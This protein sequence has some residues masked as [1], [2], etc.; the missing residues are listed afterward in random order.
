MTSSL[1]PFFEP[2]GVAIIG[3]SASSDKLSYGILKNLISYGYRGGIFPVNPKADEI[4]GLPCYPEIC[5]VPSPVDLAVIVLASKLIPSVLEECGKRGIK[6]AT[7]ISGGFKEVGEEGRSLEAEVLKI[8]AKYKIRLIGPNCVGTMNLITGLNTTF[9]KGV[10]ATGGIGFISQ[11]GAICGGVVDHVAN[12]GIG[13]S[14][15]LSLGNEADVNETDMIEYLG[16][17]ADTRVIAAYVEGIQDGQRF[18]KI[19]RQ[20]TRKKPIVILKAGQSEEG[21]K[22]VS[23]HTGSLAG[24]HAA[25]QAAFKQSDAIEVFST[26]DLLNTAMA[27]D[28]LELPRG[29]KV[30]IITNAGGPAALASD[31]LAL[32]GIHLATISTAT[33]EKLKEKL[34]PSAQTGNPVDMLGGANEDEY[35][36][37]LDLVLSDSGVD[38]ALPILVPQALVKPEKV[39]QAIVNSSRKSQKPVIACLMGYESI[40]EA[41]KILHQNHV[42]MVDFPELTGVMFGALYKRSLFEKVTYKNPVSEQNSGIETVKS[43]FNKNTGK[44]IWGENDTR[45]ILS[46]YGIPLIEGGLVNSIKDGQNFANSIRYPIVMKVA[47]SQLLH[48]SEAGVVKVGILDD[49]SFAENYNQL[50]NKAKRF[51]AKAII[52]GIL[53]EKLAPKGEEVIIGMKRD[54]GFGPMM[55]FGMGGVFVELYKDVSFRI[56]P[57][58]VDDA[59]DMIRETKAF[60]LLNGWRGGSRFDIE[61]ITTVIMKLS[62]LAIDFP[63]IQEVEINPLRVLPEGDGTLGLDCRMILK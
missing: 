27:L 6:A 18:L 12:N 4:L 33:Q 1:K 10:P 26:T 3:A 46:A 52:E 48:K 61:A 19:T 41:R 21:A 39:A 55:M 62:Q 50:I 25:Y 5:Q 51:D 11:S 16:E 49:K 37:A 36:F 57:L 45:P 59:M 38:M 43:I 56:A 32:N 58:G 17:D 22:A 31:S 53:I 15:F 24:S 20:V 42:P 60:Q 63:Q 28:W 54:P 13:F 14:H 30:A 47:S 29:N 35:S 23:S 2:C 7:I 8:A 9:I 40:Q 34:N 44:K